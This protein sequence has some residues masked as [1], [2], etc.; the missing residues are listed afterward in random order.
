MGT[1]HRIAITGTPGCG[2]TTL[3][4]Q[5]AE[6]GISVQA[7][8]VIAYRH[9]LL[10]NPDPDDGAA[11]IDTEALTEA[12]AASEWVERSDAVTLID[13]H[14]SH[15]L[16]VDAVILLRCHPEVLQQRLIERGYSESKVNENV[17]A[18]LIGSIAAECLTSAAEGGTPMLEV[19]MTTIQSEDVLGVMSAWIADGFKPR[20]PDAPLDW[21]EQLH[22]GG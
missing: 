9:G 14:L 12:L 17:E 2:K 16:P 4:T 1:G 8:A 3:C 15:L 21:I 5:A 18:E 6:T 10:G 22:G 19:D 13:G 7:V 20:M 11:P